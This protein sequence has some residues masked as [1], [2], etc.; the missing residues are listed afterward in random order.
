[1]A[2]YLRRVTP[3]S[4]KVINGNAMR[5]LIPGELYVVYIE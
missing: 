1:M 5:M 4:Q 3:K 2:Q